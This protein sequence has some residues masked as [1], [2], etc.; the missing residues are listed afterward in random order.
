MRS[1]KAEA[2][3]KLAKMLNES[4]SQN[5]FDKPDGRVEGYFT[6]EE[7]AIMDCI[8]AICNIPEDPP[9][10]YYYADNTRYRVR[11]ESLDDED[12]EDA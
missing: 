7:R 9:Y 1:F 8:I 12:N 10:S 2:L 11:D 4:L 6:T 3:T 5:A